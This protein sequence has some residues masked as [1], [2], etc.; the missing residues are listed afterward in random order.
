MAIVTPFPVRTM[1][2]H[3][4]FDTCI[5]DV[6]LERHTFPQLFL[7]FAFLLDE[8]TNSP[9]SAAVAAPTNQLTERVDI[10]NFSSVFLLFFIRRPRQHT[11][12]H[13]F[14]EARCWIA[15]QARATEGW[16]NFF[17]N[18]F[19]RGGSVNCKEKEGL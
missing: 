17:V 19:G 14:K 10:W 7:D 1:T 2:R 8:L 9:Q 11:H 13:T 16:N 4:A 18:H 12:I 3:G 15:K 6:A 5:Q